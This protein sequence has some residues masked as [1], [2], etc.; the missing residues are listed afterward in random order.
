MLNIEFVSFR[1]ALD[2]S[3]RLGRAIVV[4]IGVVSEQERSPMVERV[5]AAMRGACLKAGSS[6]D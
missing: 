3:G 5:R 1:E 6:V 4:I 2:T